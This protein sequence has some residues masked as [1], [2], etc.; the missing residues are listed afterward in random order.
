MDIF[1]ILFIIAA[2]FVV[3]TSAKSYIPFINKEDFQNINKKCKNNK[4]IYKI[5]NFPNKNN[6]KLNVIENNQYYFKKDCI[7]NDECELKPNNYNF[8]QYGP[9]KTAKVSALSCDM[10]INKLP[11]RKSKV[12]NN[13]LIHKTCP[14]KKLNPHNA[15]LVIKK[16]MQPSYV[17]ETRVKIPRNCNHSYQIQKL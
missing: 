14:C 13:C 5:D 17:I 4:N 9:K 15:S 10:E 16:C 7:W 2:F 12:I 6:N 8:F 1:I 11:D 3:L